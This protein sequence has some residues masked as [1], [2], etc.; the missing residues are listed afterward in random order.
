MSRFLKWT[1]VAGG[2]L[3]AA[4]VLAVV[5]L[6]SMIEVERYRPIIERELS[7]A[8]GRPVRLSGELSLSIFPW[9]GVETGPVSVDNPEGFA[10]PRLVSVEAV[11]IRVALLPLLRRAVEVNRFVLRSPEITLERT[12]DGRANWENIGPAKPAPSESPAPAESESPDSG[13]PEP[14]TRRPAPEE[15]AGGPA[16]SDLAVEELAVTDGKAT[17]IDAAA[18]ERREVTGLNLRVE[19]LSFDQAISLEI[20]ARMD[21]QP[22]AITGEAGPVGN[23]PG[24]GTIPFSLVVQ[25]L[26]EIEAEISGEATNPTSAPTVDLSVSIS[27]FSPRRAFERLSLDFPVS[28]AD[29]EALNR[30]AL[31][32]QFQGG[33]TSFSLSDGVLE[34]D[35]ARIDFSAAL[36]SFAPL[37]LAANLEA[38]AVDVVRYLPPE[39]VNGPASGE[40]PAKDPS[41]TDSAPAPDLSALEAA[42]LDLSF[43]AGRLTL[44]EWTLTDAGLRL[45]G[46]NGRF[47]LDLSAQREGRPISLSGTVGPLKADRIGLELT[48]NALDELRATVSGALLTPAAGP[49]LDASISVEPF[50][51]RKLAEAA[52]LPFPVQTADPAALGRVGFSGKIRGGAKSL[53]V[54]NGVLTLDE[55]T[56]RF[57]MNAAA[58]SPPNLSFDLGLDR[59]DLDRYLP[60]SAETG[61]KAGTGAPPASGPVMDYAPL[62]Q[63]RVDG[64]FRA[65][66]VTVRGLELAGIRLKIFGEEGI[67][68]LDP[69]NVNLYRGSMS[70]TG[71][72]D[73]TGPEP[74]SRADLSVRGVALGPLLADA[75]DS[76]LVTGSLDASANLSAR[77]GQPDALAR[78]LNGAADL[79]LS[80]GRI[81]GLNLVN[82][83]RNLEAAFQNAEARE[84]GQADL[85]TEFTALNV[86][87][88]LENGRA[89]VTEGRL[90]SPVMEADAGGSLH[91]AE[92]TLDLRVTPTFIQPVGG[93]NAVAVPV[94]IG[95]T[96][97]RPRYRPD[98]ANLIRIDPQKTVDAILE[99]PE[100]G[101]KDLLNEQKDRI[102]SILLPGR[103][104]KEPPADP[105]R[106]TAPSGTS[107]PGK[108][109][110]EDGGEAPRGKRKEPS[111]DDAVRNLLRSLPFGN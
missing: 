103:D 19:N 21:G 5:L 96:F 25:A 51:P 88:A 41:Q 10:E 15:P 63:M 91:L 106:E 11:E 4:L 99:D 38:D 35:G 24:T 73:V 42:V 1:I 66:A 45:S 16:I 49:A 62:R 33:P 111:A 89:T 2:S 79:R 95:G 108:D 48:A 92:R 12:A 83:A 7:K 75:A 18:G 86:A 43:Q 40:S 102:R 82:M 37:Q 101:V 22:V 32:G 109:S 110:A 50:A 36:K 9:I 56:A 74:L 14:E 84:T 68:R 69:L 70:M 8:A 61:P 87:L 34:L 71:R 39:S 72:A 94:A 105:A 78:S 52:G 57:S 26:D 17:W 90:T 85:G 93:R 28:T 64:A 80:D 6:P 97:D 20:S 27:P 30:V 13:P 81:K 77:G 54:E 53:R 58:F 100:K 76:D 31:S 59:I 23:P 65:D 60:P 29:P 3:A 46:E 47:A 44:P 107:G 104:G 67:F 55:T 98:L